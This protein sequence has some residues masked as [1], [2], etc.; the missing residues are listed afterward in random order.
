L[1]PSV[2]A[3][4]ASLGEGDQNGGLPSLDGFGESGGF[5]Q[6]GIDGG[7]VEVS[8]PS[9]DLRWLV[10]GE[11]HAEPFF[12]TLGGANLVGRIMI[13]KH[14]AEPP[15]CLADRCSAAVSSSRRFSKTGVGDRAAPA[16]QIACDALPDFGHHLVG[17]RNQMPLVEGVS[18]GLCKRVTSTLNRGCGSEE[19]TRNGASA[20]HWRGGTVSPGC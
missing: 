7:V 8:P 14:P 18:D 10:L 15:R 9:P 3:L 1:N 11:Q 16:Q 19:R 20:G 4:E 12:H 6:L 2:R 13:I 17:R 5:G